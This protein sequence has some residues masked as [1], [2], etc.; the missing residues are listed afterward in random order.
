[1]PGKADFV[2]IHTHTEGSF[3]DGIIKPDPLFKK[4]S[5][6]G[7]KAVCLTD[8][9]SLYSIPAAIKAAAVT[10]V[11]AIFGSEF[12]FVEDAAESIARGDNTRY[13]LIVIAKNSDGLK[14]L[15][16][17]HNDSHEF[18]YYFSKR[19]NLGRGLLDIKLLDKY[20]DNII[21]TSACYYGIIPYM[22]Y[23]GKDNTAGKYFDIYQQMFGDDFYLEV[24]RHNVPEED[25]AFS[26]L[27][28][29]GKKYNKKVIAAQD[30]HYLD[31]ED[32]LVHELLIS[33]RFGSFSGF[34]FPNSG[35]YLK[36]SEEMFSLGF[37][38]EYYLNTCEI[39]EKVSSYEMPSDRI[40]GKVI[41]G[42]A[43][44]LSEADVLKRADMF[45]KMSPHILSRVLHLLKSGLSLD[46]IRGEDKKIGKYFS[47]HEYYAEFAEKL[48]DIPIDMGKASDDSESVSVLEPFSRYG[49]DLVSQWEKRS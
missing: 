1:M 8:H 23:I 15:V 48:K 34:R 2:H 43:E 3:S 7:Q 49:R 30:A 4:V 35:F 16:R 12:Y 45:K 42:R 5:N 26:L 25:R 18:N 28:E 10:G 46:R 24:A 32:A 39:S 29:L 37:P 44:R 22:L 33:T 38:D 11:K 9:D 21:I 17:M 14:N 27:V 41:Q 47:E 19:A 31:K 13:H 36:T 20:K 40:S 6:T